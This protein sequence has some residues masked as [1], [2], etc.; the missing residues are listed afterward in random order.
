M[1]R[2]SCVYLG[3]MKALEARRSSQFTE[4]LCT[5]PK[6]RI[7]LLNKHGCQVS[8]AERTAA[9][10]ARKA[11]SLIKGER[12]PIRKSPLVDQA[13]TQGMLSCVERPPAAGGAVCPHECANGSFD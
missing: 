4:T 3:D 1:K 8:A 5:S 11:L 6:S 2:S 12:P 10:T 9:S 7:E 13:L